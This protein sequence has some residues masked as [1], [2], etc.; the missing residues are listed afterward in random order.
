M[1]GKIL[2]GDEYELFRSFVAHEYGDQNSSNK[3]IVRFHELIKREIEPLFLC[4]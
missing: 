1:E 4:S 3:H 2:M